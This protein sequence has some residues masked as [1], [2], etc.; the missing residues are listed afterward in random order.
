MFRQKKIDTKK[1]E[2]IIVQIRSKMAAFA[3]DRF[4]KKIKSYYN[5][6]ELIKKKILSDTYQLVICIL[7]DILICNKDYG[8]L[9]KKFSNAKGR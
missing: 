1:I 5:V 8:G 6:I 4:R 9:K 7:P 3:C 2:E